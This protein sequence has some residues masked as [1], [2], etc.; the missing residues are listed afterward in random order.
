MDA[1]ISIRLPDPDRRCAWRQPLVE[2]GRTRTVDHMLPHVTHIGVHDHGFNNLSTYGN[3]LR[4]LDEG[5][6]EDEP[7]QRQLMRTPC[8]SPERSRRR[9]GP[10]RGAGSATSTRST[11]R[12]RCSSI[13]CG[14]YASSVCAHQLGHVLMGENDGGESAAAFHPTRSG[15]LQVPCVPRRLTSTRMTCEV[16]QHMKERST[17]TMAT[18]VPG[19]RSRATRRSRPGLGDW[20][21]HAGLRRGARV[22]SV[23]GT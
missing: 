4:L 16:E 6:L 21:G 15:D 9:G 3:L 8:P 10:P 22:L 1:G 23:A 13:R 12:I 5:R 20:L 2:L 7:W 14:L 19:P 18:S 17:A 11:V